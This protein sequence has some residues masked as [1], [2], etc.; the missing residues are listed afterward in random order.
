M[1]KLLK[2]MGLWPPFLAS[3]IKVKISGALKNEF[4]VSMPLRFYNKN[5]VGSHYGGSLYSMCD[6]FYMLILMDKLGGKYLVWDKAANIKF[7]KP[8]KGI[9]KAH[10]QI[11]DSKVEEIKKIVESDG[12]F[13]PVFEVEVKDEHGDTVALVEKTLWVKKKD[14]VK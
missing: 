10:F 9:V 11:P 4:E 3:G 13:E 8:G 5:Y 2:F 12:K 1:N 6:P 14:A 7:K